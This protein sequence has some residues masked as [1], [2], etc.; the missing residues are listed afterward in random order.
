[1][2]MKRKM[3][4]R[5]KRR[6]P[7]QARKIKIHRMLSKVKKL[8][9]LKT[10]HQ[11]RH[12][13]ILKEILTPR[14]KLSQPQTNQPKVLKHQTLLLKRLLKQN[15]QALTQRSHLQMLQQTLTQRSLLQMLQRTLTQ[16]KMP[17]LQKS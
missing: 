8:M 10:N 4:R 13:M 12:P 11:K 16:R 15:H 1:M 2:R 9:I 17:A 5:S 3:K 14:E 7:N 6:K